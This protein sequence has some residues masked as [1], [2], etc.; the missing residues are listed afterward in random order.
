MQY[1]YCIG[2][3]LPV[4]VAATL[5]KLLLHLSIP[6]N[7]DI[8]TYFLARA[9]FPKHTNNIEKEN[10]RKQ[11]HHHQHQTPSNIKQQHI[12]INRIQDSNPK[13]R[14][15]EEKYNSNRSKAKKGKK[16]REKIKRKLTLMDTANINY[17]IY[18]VNYLCVTHF[19]EETPQATRIKWN[20]KRATRTLNICS[21]SYIQSQI[22]IASFASLWEMVNCF[23]FS[24]RFLFF[25]FIVLPWD[26]FFSSFSNCFWWN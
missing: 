7:K 22:F 21:I 9:S 23:F 25:R 20:E 8:N 15:A 24:F 4:A 14:R 6:H 17:L 26:F 18:M 11:N 16:K 2:F 10:K 1:A 12:I 19:K 3:F 13:W 5:A